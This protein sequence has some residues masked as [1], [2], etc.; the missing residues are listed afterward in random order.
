M[1]ALKQTFRADVTERLNCDLHP[2][3]GEVGFGGTPI[4]RMKQSANAERS[5]K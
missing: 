4:R 5:D 2:S 1:A 3:T